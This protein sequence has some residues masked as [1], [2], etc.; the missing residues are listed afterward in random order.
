MP[1]N[2]K[3]AYPEMKYLQL[4]KETQCTEQLSCSSVRLPSSLA[5]RPAL[6]RCTVFVSALVLLPFV[7]SRHAGEDQQPHILDALVY[8][9]SVCDSAPRF[10]GRAPL[11]QQ[12]Q[13]RR[14]HR[15]PDG[16]GTG[17]CLH[18]HSQRRHG[19]NSPRCSARVWK[20]QLKRKFSL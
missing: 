19:E 15:H 7:L 4:Q 6:W 3:G 2:K 8:S 5:E 13:R 20:K 1:N 12:W 10:L 14:K 11:Q 17:T 18:F 16:P 9:G